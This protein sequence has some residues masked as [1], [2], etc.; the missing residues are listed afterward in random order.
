MVLILTLGFILIFFFYYT[1]MCNLVH[2]SPFGS[3]AHFISIF[4]DKAV[5][6]HYFGWIEGNMSKAYY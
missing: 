4:H 5:G 2:I 3:L 6:K 1:E